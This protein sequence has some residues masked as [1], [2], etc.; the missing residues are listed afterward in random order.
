MTNEQ[1][2]GILLEGL[3]W[4]L[5]QGS[6]ETRI[7]EIA[8]DSRKAEKG[9]LFVA[10]KGFSS[11]GHTY[12]QDAVGRGASVV[13]VEDFVHLAEEVTV[14]QVPDTRKAMAL[15]SASFFSWP[16]RD[17]KVIGITGTNGKTT[18][19]H[20]LQSIFES[21][22]KKTG[23][24][25]TIGLE[26]DG[27]KIPLS[28]TTPEAPDLQRILRQMVERGVQYCFMEVSSHALEL[29]R[30]YGME[31]QGGI[32]TNL[33]P[34]HLELHGTMEQYFLAKAR[35]FGMVSKY[36]ILNND[37]PYGKIIQ[38][39]HISEH[40]ACTTYGMNGG[41]DVW[42]ESVRYGAGS[43]EFRL[44]SLIGEVSLF[45]RLPGKV[46]LYN[47]LA[48][49]ATA[50]AE[51]VRLEVIQKGMAALPG[52]AGR[53]ETVYQ[54]HDYHVVIDFAHTEAG[55]QEVLETIRPFAVNR[56][57]LVFGVYAAPGAAGSPK[58]LAMGQVAGRYADLS[59]VTSDNPKYQDPAAIIEEVAQ[60]IRQAGGEYLAFIDRKEAIFHGISSMLPGD[61]LMITDKGHETAQIIEGKAIPFNEKQIVLEAISNLK[62]RK[63]DNA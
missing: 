56:V 20:I 38:Q 26:I 31:F 37:D 57:L 16:A 9:T 62:A 53:F 24:I 4:Q 5:L 59:F 46:N 52:V 61:V 25:G 19:I 42:P 35:L 44:H 50:I 58:R 40:I 45:L 36:A 63:A 33:T 14:I 49:A 30:V 1:P 12:I 6:P 51:G 32:F 28:N 8:Y 15:I 11:D 47:A 22:G 3:E 41:S 29:F 43:I 13:L 55:L 34:D 60:G 17:M 23:L 2:I 27:E 21:W 7:R 39:S 48:A 54:D 10:V 18:T